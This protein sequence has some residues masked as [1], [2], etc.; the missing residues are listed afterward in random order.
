MIDYKSLSSNFVKQRMDIISREDYLSNDDEEFIS[1]N[2]HHSV[3]DID[4]HLI[5][6][7]ENSSATEI[8][9]CIIMANYYIND[10]NVL[11]NPSFQS[12]IRKILII[13]INTNNEYD[14]KLRIDSLWL[15]GKL[16]QTNNEAIHF[17]KDLEI[18]DL[19]L[20]LFE[21]NELDIQKYLLF[22][23]RQFSL[24]CDEC[25]F[26]LVGWLQN[27]ENLFILLK[28]YIEGIDPLNE[29]LKI[30]SILFLNCLM[31]KPTCFKITQFC[32]DTFISV[33]N[34]AEFD[35]LFDK[36]VIGLAY[37]I[38]NNDSKVWRP[39]LTMCYN[40]SN[41]S[42]I[43]SLI[44][45][46]DFIENTMII[47]NILRVIIAWYQ[48]NEIIENLEIG[49]IINLLNY[50][51]NNQINP[52]IQN[53]AHNEVNN[54]ILNGAMNKTTINEHERENAKKYQRI[55]FISS[56]T[57]NTL[58]E[59][60][61]P[62]IVEMVDKNVLEYSM[63][64]YHHAD[65]QSKINISILCSTIAVHG[66]TGHKK[67]MIEMGFLNMFVDMFQSKI[68]DLSYRSV[69]AIYS[70]FQA[71]QCFDGTNICTNGFIE[72]GGLDE[73]NEILEQNEDEKLCKIAHLLI[74]D[75]FAE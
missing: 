60:G 34:E 62:F 16:L 32:L 58:A 6:A 75:Y 61:K 36:A 68:I 1:S 2:A 72:I 40:G 70:L 53:E 71:G 67:K 63:N 30:P 14:M 47:S 42:F 74:N 28:Q 10:E 31:K 59:C 17:L 8:C 49:A 41:L 15:I 22:C 4:F 13:I 21:N 20:T 55:L 11:Y 38:S 44:A 45:F 56:F 39:K 65:Y 27:H 3:E 66:Q 7:I 57:L 19:F 9:Q 35:N 23:L 69:S 25:H 37:I 12:F 26:A 73:I 33:I 51:L 46:L 43:D 54:G 29:K 24:H 48:K 50:S 52:E 18:L 64:A 5:Q